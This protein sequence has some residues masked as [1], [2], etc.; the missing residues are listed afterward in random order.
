[1]AKPFLS[2]FGKWVAGHWKIFAFVVIVCL[3]LALG[4]YAYVMMSARRQ[5]L[6]DA[7]M[8]RVIVA[9][10]VR[11]DLGVIAKYHGVVLHVSQY[12]PHPFVSAYIPKDSL[13]SLRLEP[14]VDFVQ[15]EQTYHI[16][17]ITH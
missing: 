5:P 17:A 12:S 15:I 7:E 6:S 14:S 16:D 11:H 13:E 4:A 2:K 10:K 3:A 1:M 9:F 8:V